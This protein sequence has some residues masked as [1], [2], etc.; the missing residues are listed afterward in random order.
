[1]NYR[2]LTTSFV[3]FVAFVALTG[4]PPRAIRAQ[5]PI[6]FTHV[7]V[8]DGADS[9][10]RRDQTVIVRGTRI[11]AV[12]PA[13]STTRAPAMSRTPVTPLAT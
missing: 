13:S 3:A 8:I 12:G 4:A 5:P 10:P 6:A 2:R 7:T 11:A 9:V 1:V